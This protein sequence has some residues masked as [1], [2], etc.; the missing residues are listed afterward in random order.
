MPR[1]VGRMGQTPVVLEA[2]LRRANA[3]MGL[4]VVGVAV[5]CAGC[6]SPPG[7]QLPVTPSAP[8]THTL[9]GVVIA[10]G[11]PAVG[12]RVTVLETQ[13]EPSATTDDNGRY[14]ISRLETSWFWGRT[15]VRFSK[16][17]YFTDFQRPNIT[18]DTRLDVALDRLVFI[19]LGLDVRGRVN[20]RDALCAGQDYEPEPCQRFALITPIAGTLEV[21][22][23]SSAN[24]GLWA[25]DVVKPDGHAVAEFNGSPK[26]VSLPASVGGA[27]EIRVVGVSIDFELTTSLR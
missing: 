13:S 5:L 14:S 21:S 20:T 15:L 27:Y 3:A 4:L 23:T 12:A 10:E 18:Q 2:A 26:R 19:P 1:A 24:P 25:L 11:R 8:R 22:L 9:S 16:P 6:D 7:S 17:G